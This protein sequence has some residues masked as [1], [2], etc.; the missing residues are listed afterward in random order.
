MKRLQGKSVVVTGAGRGLGRAYALS[1]AAE[2]ANVLVNDLGSDISGHGAS[3]SPADE[4][5]SEIEATGGQ[6]TAD[7]ND[8][9]DYVQA[10]QIIDAAVNSF[11]H[12]D[13]IVTNAGMD[14]RGHIYELSPEDWRDTLDVHVNGQFNCSAH[15]ARIMKEQQSGSIINVTSGAF[16]LGVTRLGAYGASKGAVFGL[17][18]TLAKEMEPF[19]VRVNCVA[20]ALTRTRAVDQFLVSLRTV[21]GIPIKDVQAMEATI[22]QPEEIA[23]MVV[24]LVSDASKD[25]SG[26]AFQVDRQSVAVMRPILKPEEQTTNEIWDI[27]DLAAVVPGMVARA[28]GI[29][30]ASR[31]WP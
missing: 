14:R 17:M 24:Y 12:L 4:V 5:V 7:Y 22:A 27:D 10:G 29:K 31:Q 20:P 19:N 8:V 18:R 28:M 15:A 16:Y 30:E 23:P 3:A 11:G 1:L 9:T 2:G 21:E 26:F 25:I 6:A 13:A